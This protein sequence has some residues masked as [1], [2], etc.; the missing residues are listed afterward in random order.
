MQR[1]S[2]QPFESIESAYDFFRVLSDAVA[3]AK[4]DIEVLI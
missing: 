4:R 3:D 1:Q 2:E